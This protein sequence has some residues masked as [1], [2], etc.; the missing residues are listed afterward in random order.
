MSQVD[1]LYERLFIEEEKLQVQLDNRS[2]YNSLR[3]QLAKRHREMVESDATTQSLCSSFDPKTNVATFWVG[4]SRQT[5]GLSF[6]ILE[7]V[8]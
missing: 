4:D 5:R 6:T 7:N 3:V 8:R 2:G 1:V